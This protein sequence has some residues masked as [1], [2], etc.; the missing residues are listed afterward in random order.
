MQGVEVMLL[1]SMKPN[2]AHMFTQMIGKVCKGVTRHQPHAFHLSFIHDTSAVET[3]LEDPANFRSRADDTDSVPHTTK[4]NYYNALQAYARVVVPFRQETYDFYRNKVMEC[5]AT[6]RDNS[7]QQRLEGKEVE[8]WPT[9]EEFSENV[10][11]LEELVG[12]NP[13]DVVDH[14]K[15]LLYSIY[16]G[17][18]D[19]CVL[20]LDFVYSTRTSL[21]QGNCYDKGHLIFNDYKTHGT[22]GAKFIKLPEELVKKIET[23]LSKWP[24]TY[25]FPKLVR[26]KIKDEPMTQPGA[27]Q[28]VKS[29]WVATFIPKTPTADDIRSSLT[30]RFFNIHKDILSRE[31]FA[32]QSMSGRD[33]ME[34]F[35][36][37]VHA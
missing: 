27:S 22:Y 34:R 9:Y 25:L 10:R 23:S 19:T 6:Y 5:N 21:A 29:A 12:D 30:T 31:S 37:K 1:S 20:R 11:L 14:M 33:T 13:D 3:F 35:Y 24:R 2:T 8:R 26:K 4:K 36:Y 32:N 17:L 15:W 7:L 28:F 18:K 16:D